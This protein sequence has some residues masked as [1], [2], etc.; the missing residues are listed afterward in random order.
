[1]RV[2]EYAPTKRTPGIN[3][4]LTTTKDELGMGGVKQAII[5]VIVV[6]PSIAI[7][8][9]NIDAFIMNIFRLTDVTSQSARL[10]DDQGRMTLLSNGPIRRHPGSTFESSN[11]L[12]SFSGTSPS[13]RLTVE[14]T[15]RSATI[16]SSASA[17]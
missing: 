9:G 13:L 7:T 15:G 2:G 5:L 3:A 10:H 8:N 16:E 4:R 1:M 17:S 6:N 14:K 11:P 12:N